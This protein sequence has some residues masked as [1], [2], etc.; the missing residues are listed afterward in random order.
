MTQSA[1]RIGVP[2]VALIVLATIIY[3][4]GIKPFREINALKGSL[5]TKDFLQLRSNALTGVAQALG[6][7][8]LLTGLFFTWRSVRAT[9]AG[10]RATQESTAKS[11]AIAQEGQITERFTRA[12]EQ[13]GNKESLSTRLGGIYALERIATDSERDHWPVMEILTTYIRE[14]AA[15][16]EQANELAEPLPQEEA[17]WTV[18]AVPVPPWE[19]EHARPIP[20]LAK[21]IQAN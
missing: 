20:A 14:N 5:E 1:W 21:D 15:W 3:F 9:E 17:A 6:G 8:I 13:L 2:L 10:I 7:A 4:F 12:I 11:L 19:Q 18:P 16:K